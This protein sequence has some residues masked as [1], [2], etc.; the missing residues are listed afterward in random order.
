MYFYKQSFFLKE[1]KEGKQKI[2]TIMKLSTVILVIASLQIMATGYSQTV[3]LNFNGDPMSVRE[4]LKEIKRQTELSFMF[5][6]D[7]SSLNNEVSITAHNRNIKDVLTQL[8]IDTVLDY[9]ILNEK[10]IVI[11]PKHVLQGIVITGTVTEAGDKRE[12]HNICSVK[13]I[14]K[15]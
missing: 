13:L 8:F 5:S 7:I 3:P 2:F 6:D 12:E 15:K 9:Q 1:K 14:N 4:L 11:A 10:L